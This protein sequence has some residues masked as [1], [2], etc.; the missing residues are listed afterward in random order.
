MK[1]RINQLIASGEFN[2]IDKFGNLLQNPDLFKRYSI[3]KY[4]YPYPIGNNMY[5]TTFCFFFY[6][7]GYLIETFYCEL[8]G[9]SKEMYNLKVNIYN[10]P[11]NDVNR[12]SDWEW[13]DVN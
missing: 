2:H 8:E 7:S 12:S 10:H 11:C 6:S 9:L 4:D 3:M 1:D 5:K 13:V